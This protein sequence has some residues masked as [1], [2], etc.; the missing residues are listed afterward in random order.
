M[1]C[2]I[3]QAVWYRYPFS[4][5][6]AA[7]G[8]CRLCVLAILLLSS[9]CGG[10]GSGDSAEQQD[11]G[12]NGLPQ[13]DREPLRFVA[14]GATGEGNNAQAEV[15]AA[16]GRVC[17]AESC[18]LVLLLGDN[19]FDCGVTGTS[20]SQFQSKFE[21][22][23]AGLDL[24]FYVALGNHDYGGTVLFAGDS[25]GLGNE[26]GRAQPQI[27]YAG[28][29]NQWRMPGAHYAFRA[30]PAGFIVLDTNS[31]LWGDASYGEQSIWIADALREVSGAD[32]IFVIGHHAYLSNGAT[33]DAGSYHAIEI[34]GVEVALPLPILEG[35]SVKSFLENYVCGS[36]D[37]YLSAGDNSRQW[38]DEADRFCGT[39]LIVSGAGSKT[40]PLAAAGHALHYGDDKNEGFLWVEVTADKVTGRFYDKTGKLDYQRA[41]GK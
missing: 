2:A 26:F 37:F 23:Y 14:M 24:P 7:K 27:D 6:R 5:C 11:A 10:S 25:C 29:V 18:D 13:T 30:G 4:G 8:L 1:A 34:N 39:E 17:A 40:R 3:D 22:P 41:V 35:A 15:A 21:F 28:M 36:A 38:L 16:I 31:I 33:G 9:A 32:W 19:F 12:A 20:D